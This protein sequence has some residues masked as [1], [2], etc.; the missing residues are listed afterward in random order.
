MH[1]AARQLTGD[2]GPASKS[3]DLF[4]AGYPVIVMKALCCWYLD[5][6]SDTPGISNQLVSTGVVSGCSLFLCA[7]SLLN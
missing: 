6:R 7:C 4:I 3:P 1:R 5:I 2:L